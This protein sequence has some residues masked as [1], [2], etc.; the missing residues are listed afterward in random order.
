MD[1]KNKKGK[2]MKAYKFVFGDGRPFNAKDDNPFVY[3][4]TV[5]AEVSHDGP[6]SFCGSGLHFSKTEQQ[7]VG[8]AKFEPERGLMFLEVEISEDEIATEDA[9]KFVLKSGAKAKITAVQN[10]HLKGDADEPSNISDGN[11]MISDNATIQHVWGN[12]TIQDV[13]DNATIQDVRGNATIQCVRDNATIQCVRGNATIQCVRGNATIQDVRGNAT[14]QCVRDNAT[15]QDV[16]DNATIITHN[17]KIVL[18]VED[19]GGFIVDRSG[20]KP[21]GYDAAGWIARNKREDATK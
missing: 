13:R 3:P 15:I 9:D 12:A 19:S 17:G 6:V 4:L 2:T 21:V 10:R 7:A 11:W 1:R 20:N 16:R 5:G 8:Y 18:I 14:I